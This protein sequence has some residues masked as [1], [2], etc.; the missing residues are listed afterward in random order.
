[1][2]RRQFVQHTS[3]ALF[4]G[5]SLPLSFLKNSIPTMNDGKELLRL[6]ITTNDKGIPRLLDLQNKTDSSEQGGIPDRYGLHHA[7]TTANVLQRWTSAFVAE[8]SEFYHSEK[9]AQAITLAADFLQR[10]QHSDGTIDLLTTNFHST[11]DTAFVVEPLCLSYTLLAKA[12]HSATAKCL[13]VL[14]FFL[15]KAGDALTVGGIHTPNHRWVVCMALARL[16]TLFP[17]EKYVQRIDEWL[18]EKIDIDPDGQYTEKSTNIYSPLTNRCLITVARLLDR[19]DLY[20]PVRRNLDMTLYYIHPNGEVAT[21]AS[22]RQD[23]YQTGTLT[24]YFYPY[25]YM[26]LHDENGQFASISAM[27]PENVSWKRLV[28]NLAYLQED[29]SLLAPLPQPIPLPENYAKVFPH[30]KLVRIRRGDRD[31]TILADNPIFFTFQKGEAVLQGMRL[32]SAFFGKGQFEAEKVEENNGKFVLAQQLEAP[33]YQPFPK[34]K[35]PEDGDWEK[36]PRE[37]RSQSEVQHLFTKIEIEE[38]DDGFQLMFDISG[39]DNV[40]LAIELGF[41]KG[42]TLSNMQTIRDLTDAFLLKAER[43]TYQFAHDQIHF[44]PGHHVHTWTQLRGA[45]PKLDADCVYITGF[46]P[47]QYRLQ[48]S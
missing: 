12:S 40:P 11:P 34:E 48:I 13:T 33:Y 42:G 37:E 1:M 47:F 17:N 15:R 38:T 16:Q 46:T 44:G 7:M 28:Q 26:A 32:A 22:G 6:L 10:Q 5:A 20:E 36:M 29:A 45:L 8:Q 9:L 39:T 18:A 4:L 25:R 41:R 35:L 14:E 24:N 21:E 27:I 2:H 30:S 19:P 3:T 31:A 23:Q 43:G